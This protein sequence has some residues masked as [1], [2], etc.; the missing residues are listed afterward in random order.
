MSEK[1]DAL[2][3]NGQTKILELSDRIIEYRTANDTDV[4]RA[5]FSL[6]RSLRWS[7][8][9]VLVEDWRANLRQVLFVMCNPSTADAFKLDPTVGRCVK[10]ARFWG[11]GMLE[12]VNLYAWRSQFPKDVKNLLER[13]KR[14]GRDGARMT[15]SDETNDE[16][17]IAAAD[18]SEMIVCA[19]GAME[20]T[21][22]RGRR[23]RD[24]LSP[25]VLYHL[26][27]SQDG[28]PKHP[29]ARGKASIP[30]TQ[31]PIRWS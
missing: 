22:A 1:Y 20:F 2:G 30:A 26:G 23:V 11:F 4:A 21:W 3:I 17:I 14:D 7:L 10:H 8:G 19:W 6:D 31:Q 16:I 13:A 15:G 27:K 29:L 18:R 12:V 28:H 9:R 5:E 24:M 25:R